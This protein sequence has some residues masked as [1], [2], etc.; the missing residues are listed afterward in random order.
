MEFTI[1]QIAGIIDGEVVGDGKK[2]VSQ[3]KGIE[4]AKEGSISFLSNPKY[5]S[6]IYSTKASAVIVAR[7]F[8]PAKEISTTL[9]KVSDPYLSFTSLLEE[10]EKISS[11]QK[12]GKEDPVFVGEQSTY[13]DNI[14]LGAF[15]YIGK[16]VK[17][18]DNVKIH[19]Q[20]YIGDN[21]IIGNNCIFYPGVKVYSG[22]K[23]GNHCTLHAGA[24]I[25]SD[26]FG[27]AP[28]KDGSY[29]KI[30]QLGNVIL[31]DHVDI[32]ANTTVDCAT[33]EST[34]IKKGVKLDNLVMIAH[35]VEVGE[36]TVVAAQ[37]GISGSTKIGKKVIIAG[38]V[39]VVGHIKI[40]D[41]VILTAQSGVSKDVPNNETIFGSPGFEKGPYMRSYAV[42]KKLPDVMRRIQELEQKIL[43]LPTK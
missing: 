26:G 36:N 33:L 37:S 1:D 23:I 8:K 22:T 30:P 41:G 18:G 21:S 34:V 25:G 6:F 32:G 7:D 2:K 20:V 4:D 19:P 43:N 31:E 10:Y 40:G 35:N 27:Y 24:V 14:Y 9:I 13:G 3:I 16:N 38:Q 11:F 12:S 42:F 15:S 29:K 5:E 39:G 17:I 28:Q